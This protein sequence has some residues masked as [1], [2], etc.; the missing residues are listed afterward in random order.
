MNKKVL[1]VVVALLTLAMLATPVLA[2]PTQG[3]KLPARMLILGLEIT[4]VADRTTNGGILII[5]ETVTYPLILLI[6]DGEAPLAGT[7]VSFVNSV[8]NTNKFKK[9]A[10][11]DLVMSF[12][13]P[14]GGFEGNA[15]AR[16]T[17]M[18]SPDWM[19]Y[20]HCVLQGF[21]YF[22]GQTLQLSYN[23][24]LTFDPVAGAWTGY[25]LKP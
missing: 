5:S 10:Q 14:E 16:L 20:I 11:Y 21:G 2:L 25:I 9:V 6:V 18:Y 1:G 3:L 23:G 24:P 7:V 22:E 8:D 15:E 4:P 19:L 17:S 12:A 13:A